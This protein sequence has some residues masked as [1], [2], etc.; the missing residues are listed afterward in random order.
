MVMVAVA[1]PGAMLAAT[2]A[3]TERT[4]LN[5]SSASSIS[6]CSR[7]KLKGKGEEPTSISALMTAT[8]SLPAEEKNNTLLLIVQGSYTI[9]I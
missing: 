5:I 3:P 4:R 1:D 9:S 6:S 2:P 7:V 8:K